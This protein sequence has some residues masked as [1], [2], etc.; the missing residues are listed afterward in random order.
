MN[1]RFPYHFRFDVWAL[2]LLAV[3]LAANI[4]W[5]TCPP[6]PDPFRMICPPEPDP[7]RVELAMLVLGVVTSVLRMLM[8]GALLFLAR[9]DAPE[10][11]AKPWKMAT[12]VCVAVYLGAWVG[13]YHGLT[14]LP[15]ILMLTITP[16]CA[17]ATFAIG[18]RNWLALCLTV[19]F[20]VGH[21]VSSL[22]TFA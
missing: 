18:R 10:R 13:L 12:V 3:E 11:M 7:F 2:V 22:A 4:V 14:G 9:K 5:F 8:I 20:L 6:E 19:L 16:C 17:F 1:P 21:L 15:V